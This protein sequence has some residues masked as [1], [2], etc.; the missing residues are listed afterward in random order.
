MTLFPEYLDG[1]EERLS[2]RP[3]LNGNRPSRDDYTYVK[4]FLRLDFPDL[5]EKYPHIN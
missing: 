2:T 1:L 3:F 4:D 5:A